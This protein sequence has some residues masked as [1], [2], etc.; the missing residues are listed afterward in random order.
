MRV[1]IFVVEEISSSVILRCSRSLR[2]FS[3][4]DGTADS[5]S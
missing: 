2:S 5:G 4:N 1:L 3:P